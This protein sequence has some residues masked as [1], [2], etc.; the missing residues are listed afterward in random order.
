MIESATC[1]QSSDKVDG[2]TFA[3]DFLL[4]LSIF[5]IVLYELVGNEHSATHYISKMLFLDERQRVRR[6]ID[7]MTTGIFLFC[8]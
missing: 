8:A 5:A 7:Q 3:W 6:S 4:K 1:T 2:V